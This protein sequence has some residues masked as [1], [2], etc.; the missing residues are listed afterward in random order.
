MKLQPQ[1][2]SLQLLFARTSQG[3]LPP[4][5]TGR[6]L[7]ILFDRPDLTSRG[8]PNLLSRGGPNLMSKRRSCEVDSRRPQDVLSMSPKG[9]SEYSNLDISIFSFRTY[10]IDQIYL[11][12]FQHSRFIE[13]LKI[14][15]RSSIFSKIS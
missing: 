4:T 14:L 11:K 7:K 6:P 10:S 3:R 5:S 9:T 2:P 15:L 12:V 13:N 8:R 1:I